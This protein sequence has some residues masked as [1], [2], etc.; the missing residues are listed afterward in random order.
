MWMKAMCSEGN[1]GSAKIR[2]SA[3][4]KQEPEN[5]RINSHGDLTVFFQTLCTCKIV[6][7]EGARDRA[8]TSTRGPHRI[9]H[10]LFFDFFSLPAPAAAPF[11]PNGCWVCFRSF[12]C[13]SRPTAVSTARSKISCTPN[14]SLLLHST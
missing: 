4:V 2:Y 6:R 12:I 9:R 14:I 10:S 11:P 13:I 5:G 8:P 7:T 3:A 1:A